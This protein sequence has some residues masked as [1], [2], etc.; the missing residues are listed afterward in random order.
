MN[1]RRIAGHGTI[2][3]VLAG[4]AGYA[5]AIRVPDLQ[6]GLRWWKATTGCQEL[7]RSRVGDLEVS[8]LRMAAPRRALIL[9][10]GGPGALEAPESDSE[11][12][13]AVASQGIVDPWGNTLA[14]R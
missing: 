5:P 14:V 7:A 1:G 11:N 3:A 12:P 4:R 2:A 10:I 13:G 8:L 9:V 6:G